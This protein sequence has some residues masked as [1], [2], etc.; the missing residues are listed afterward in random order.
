MTTIGQSL[1][2]TGEIT[3]QEDITLHG[4]V[5]GQIKME[6]GSLL[7]A[8]T[9]Q[10]DAEVHGSTVTIQGKLSG[11]V[12]VDKRLELTSGSAVDGTLTSPAVVLHDGAVFNGILDMQKAGA[13]KNPAGLRIAAPAATPAPKSD[14]KAS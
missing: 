5:N 8:P 9:G 1:V 3:S 10:V 2:I 7:V 13:A 4:R 12:T 14:A 6:S 11:S